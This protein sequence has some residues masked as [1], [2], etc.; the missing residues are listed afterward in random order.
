ML[1]VAALGTSACG[2]SSLGELPL[3]LRPGVGDGSYQVTVEMEQVANLVPNAEVMVA[4]VPVGSVVKTDV[5]DWKAVLTVGLDQTAA[6]P[7]NAVAR[8]AQKSLLGAEYLELAPP[9]GAAP[10]GRLADGDV[11]PLERTGRY[12]ETEELLGA[13]SVVL[14]GSGLQQVRTITTE[15]NQVFDGRQNDLRDLVGN[16]DQF[17]GG[18]DAQRDDIVRAI[19]SVNRLGATLNSDRE[20]LARGIDTIPSALKVLNE[21]REN[22]VRT[23]EN[24]QR[25][26]AAVGTLSDQSKEDLLANLRQVRP[27]IQRLA[28][29]NKDLTQGLELLLTFPFPASTAFPGM[30]KGDYGNLFLTLDLTPE[31]LRRNLLDGFQLPGRDGPGV[32]AVPPLGAPPQL[33][34]PLEPFR[35]LQKPLEDVLPL[36]G[37]EAPADGEQ[38]PEPETGSEGGVLG[39][40]LGGGR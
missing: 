2:F 29:S 37:R 13:L 22:L 39:G 24:L 1:T 19:E 8:V 30:F 35:D 14:N 3:P 27:A 25:L 6:L 18:L 23:L 40:L 20:T 38:A 10:E 12:P 5:S 4:D 31:V 7:A 17:V 36:P 32:L 9:D 11:I 16:L 21:D 33:S 26:D 34:A 15:L 28:D